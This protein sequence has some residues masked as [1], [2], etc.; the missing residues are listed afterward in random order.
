MSSSNQ[1]VKITWLDDILLKLKSRNQ[2]HHNNIIYNEYYCQWKNNIHYENQYNIIQYD[3]A[4]LEHETS[5]Y[6]KKN[7]YQLAIANMNHHITFL[8]NELKILYYNNCSPSL[9]SSLQ[10]SSSSSSSVTTSAASATASETLSEKTSINFNKMVF[11]QKINS[12]LKEE[13][14][15]VIKNELNLLT[16]KYTNINEELT[17][18][19][20]LNQELTL[21][22]EDCY[23]RL[24]EKDELMLKLSNDNEI[25]TNRIMLEKEKNINELNE[26]NKIL[27]GSIIVA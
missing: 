14:I 9:T 8:S 24:K 4:L 18:S 7:N 1:Q 15:K 12:L 17:I 22:I 2:L 3:L 21:E 5:D 26:M 19:K 11:D 10:S 20:Q 13:E 16:N 27:E 25:L 23:H 6:I